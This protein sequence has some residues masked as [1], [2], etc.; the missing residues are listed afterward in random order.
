MASAAALSRA[1]ILLF[2]NKCLLLLPLVVGVQ[3]MV[4]VLLF[5]Y[6]VL[7]SFAIILMEGMG[8]GYFG[9]AVSLMT[10]DCW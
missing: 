8:A 3:C 9:L 1:M 10:C 6:F 5:S 4:L 7:L 2:L